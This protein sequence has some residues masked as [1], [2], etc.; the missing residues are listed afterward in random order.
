MRHSFS[1]QNYLMEIFHL[2]NTHVSVKIVDLGLLFT[3]YF[4]DLP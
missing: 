4:R 1:N 2:C 3:A